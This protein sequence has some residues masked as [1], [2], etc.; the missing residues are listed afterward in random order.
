MKNAYHAYWAISR[1]S[2]SK[3]GISILND[4]NLIKISQIE[5]IGER[6]E[7]VGS[8]T[9]I[10]DLWNSIKSLTC[11][12]GIQEEEEDNGAEEIFREIMAKNF[13]KLTIFQS[14]GQRSSHISV[15]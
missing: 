1:I 9:E 10:Q 13:P 2:I 14:T 4:K 15:G 7:E 12:I 8:R 3:G 11:V 5:K 6:R